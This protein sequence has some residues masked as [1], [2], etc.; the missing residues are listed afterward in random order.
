MFTQVSRTAGHD[1]RTA[2]TS[3]SIGRSTL[4]SRPPLRPR[5]CPALC[6]SCSRRRHP[7]RRRRAASVRKGPCGFLSGHGKRNMKD[8]SQRVGLYGDRACTA[9]TSRFTVLR[10]GHVMATGGATARGTER[11]GRRAVS[12]PACGGQQQPGPSVRRRRIFT[13]SGWHF[14]G[15]QGW[16]VG[17]ARTGRPAG[18]RSPMATRPDIHQQPPPPSHASATGRSRARVSKRPGPGPERQQIPN[19]SPTDPEQRQVVGQDGRVSEPD[20]RGFARA[21]LAAA[22][23]ARERGRTGCLDTGTR[24]RPRGRTRT[25]KE[26]R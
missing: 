19:T 17:G 20:V 13:E 7:D 16:F 8:L 22:V 25:R 2:L 5:L 12:A 11:N 24:S 18:G 23:E 3:K 4:P 9:L 1:D 6:P 26:G 15:V 14:S 10:L 21:L